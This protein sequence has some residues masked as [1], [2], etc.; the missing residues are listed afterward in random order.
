MAV[1]AQTAD[2]SLVAFTIETV[3]CCAIN[4][5]RFDGTPF[6]ARG[7]ER[8]PALDHLNGWLTQLMTA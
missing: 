1:S 6:T 2:L 5:E 8:I 7:F 4:L 3:K